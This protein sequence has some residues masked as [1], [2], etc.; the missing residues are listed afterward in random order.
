VPLEESAVIQQRVWLAAEEKKCQPKKS[1]TLIVPGTDYLCESS[2]QGEM[3]EDRELIAASREGDHEA[4]RTIVERHKEGVLG[5]AMSRVRDFDDAQDVAQVTFVEA[6]HR[7]GSLKDGA[8]LGFWLRSIAHNRAVD[9]VRSRRR[10]AEVAAAAEPPGAVPTPHEE[11]EQI[12]I[13]DH[14]WAA[15]ERLKKPQ[16]EAVILHYLSGYTQEEVATM[17]DVPVGTVKYRLHEARTAW[18]G[19]LSAGDDAPSLAHAPR[20]TTCTPAGLNQ[21]CQR[22]C[23]PTRRSKWPSWGLRMSID[24]FA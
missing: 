4:F 15:L 3:E 19:G 12:E 13:R 6:Y 5:V 22:R 9:A 11:L 24:R 2:L 10:A 17:L 18:Q 8:K 21:R 7:L 16:R 1:A 14:V 23:P 20:S